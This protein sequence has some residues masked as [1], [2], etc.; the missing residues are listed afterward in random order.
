MQN[1]S[2][3]VYQS[4]RQITEK[5][6]MRVRAIKDKDGITITDPK[7]LRTGGRSIS[8]SCTMSTTQQTQQF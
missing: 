8:K 5:K 6:E 4:V 1:K 7:K 3:V 2:R